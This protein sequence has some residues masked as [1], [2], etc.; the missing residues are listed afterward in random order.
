MTMGKCLTTTNCAC[1]RCGRSPSPTAWFTQN[2][3]ASVVDSTA[4]FF[5]SAQLSPFVTVTGNDGFRAS[6]LLTKRLRAQFIVVRQFFRRDA[7]QARP[8]PSCGVCLCVCLC[9]FLS[10]TL[11][12]C[13][14]TNKHIIQIFS[15]SGSHARHSSFSLPNRIAIFRREPP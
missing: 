11:V 5:N 13:V 2:G 6:S 7:N 1:G 14:K 3:W 10:V 15:P 9:V 4:D 12:S 8:L